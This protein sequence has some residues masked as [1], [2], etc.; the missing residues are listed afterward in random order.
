MAGARPRP[1][2]QSPGPVSLKKKWLVSKTLMASMSMAKKA[3]VAQMMRSN[4]L[5]DH[6]GSCT[7]SCR[8]ATT[9]SLKYIFLRC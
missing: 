2:V 7:K 3:K 4:A 6:F 8:R 1:S 5:M 9:R